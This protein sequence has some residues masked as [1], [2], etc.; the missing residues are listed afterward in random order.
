MLSWLLRLATRLRVSIHAIARQA[1]GIDDPR[2]FSQWWCRP[3]PQTLVKISERSALSAERVREMTLA[4]L[5]TG[6]PRR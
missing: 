5:V 3:D 6:L 1:F 2:G 4:P